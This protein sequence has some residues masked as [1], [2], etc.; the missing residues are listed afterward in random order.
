MCVLN[1]VS[2]VLDG[3]KTLTV[4]LML[5]DSVEEYKSEFIEFLLNSGALKIGGPFKLKSGRMSPYFLNAGSFDDG[6]TVG[7][8]GRF[9]AAAALARFGADSFD[10]VVGPPYKG[11]QLAVATSIG[12][13]QNGVKKGFAYYRKEAKTHGEATG[14]GA[15]KAQLQKELMV[16]YALANGSRVLLVDDVFTTGETKYEAVATLNSVADGITFAG[17]IIAADRQ[18]INEDGE[19]AIA[20]FY[21]DTKI[22]FLA[23][24]TV[25]EV[26]DYLKENKK[27]SEADEALFMSYLRA[28]GTKEV[29]DK[30]SLQNKRLIEGR[31]VI[32][33]CDVPFEDFESI[34]EATADNPKIGGYKIP[35]HA[36]RKGWERW[37]E[38]ARKH[39][40]KPLIYD[41]QKAGT[42]I[43]DTAGQFMRDLKASGMD[44]VILFPQSGPRTQVAWTGEAIQQGLTVFVGGEMTHPKFLRSDGGYIANEAPDETYA[45]AAR[46]GVNHFIVPGNKPDR[47][48]HYREL[49]MAEGV[50]PVFASPGLVAQGGSISEATKVAGDN[51]H[52]IV[53]RAITEKK[54]VEG[55]RAAAKE[56]TSQLY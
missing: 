15:N 6:E 2:G 34:V 47:I 16:G 30:Y 36:G 27:L 21:T 8:V 10:V 4:Y 40:G 33:A 35:A 18:E 56:L 49:I 26:I 45:R 28:W 38:A 43:P 42:D 25:S 23:V 20:Q 29:R 12:L 24:V 9:Y 19:A 32:P 17:G 48:K 1:N 44:A 7:K 41:H 53:G 3:Y 46:Q 31:T 14:S 13:A 54:T 55:I 5:G 11:I 22:P 51:W 37:V 50:D 52:G 39:T